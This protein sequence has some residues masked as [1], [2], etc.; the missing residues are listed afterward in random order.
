MKMLSIDFARRTPAPPWWAQLLFLAAC[1]VCGWELWRLGILQAGLAETR[2][3]TAEQKDLLA[4]RVPPA[5]AA[6][7][8]ELPATR[9]AAVNRAVRRLNLP[10]NNLFEALEATLPETVALLTLEPDA[11]KRMLKVGA[12]ARDSAAMLA[13]VDRMAARS[14]FSAVHLVKHEIS[15]QDAN[16]P[17]RFAVEAYWKESP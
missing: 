16:R 6:P 11:D 10:W 12:E 8:F 15:E 7:R 9:V 17:F 2:R 3:V 5:P 14:E 4:L 13:F 1:S